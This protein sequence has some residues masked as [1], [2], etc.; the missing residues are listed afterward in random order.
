MYSYGYP[1]QQQ[2][3]MTDI[4][5]VSNEQEAVNAYVAAGRSKIMFSA[6]DQTVFVKCVSM[7]GQTSMDIFDRRAPAPVP[8][9]PEYVTREELN[10]ALE[11]LKSPKKAVK[12]EVAE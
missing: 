5:Q 9:P 8:A 4:G 12:T 2:Q 7:N 1:F 6:D 3:P 10:A 11:A